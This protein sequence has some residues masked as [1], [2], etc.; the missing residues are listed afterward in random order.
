MCEQNGYFDYLCRMLHRLIQT[1]SL[2]P[3]MFQRVGIFFQACSRFRILLQMTARWVLGMEILEGKAGLERK[4]LYHQFQANFPG[5]IRINVNVEISERRER[6]V[7]G[8]KHCLYGMG[9]ER[10][11]AVT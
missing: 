3:T 6:Q 4:T 9:Y 2:S 11:Y 8:T 7:S 10:P 5:S 1:R